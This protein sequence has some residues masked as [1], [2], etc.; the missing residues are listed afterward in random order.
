MME[1][2]AML[3]NLQLSELMH[4]IVSTM[5]LLFLSTI[6]STREKTFD[7]LSITLVFPRAIKVIGLLACVDGVFARLTKL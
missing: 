1:F 5:I 4:F 3:L 2:V 7:H 6:S